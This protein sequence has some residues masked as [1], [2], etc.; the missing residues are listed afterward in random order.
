[1][2]GASSL[3]FE[4]LAKLNSAGNYNSVLVAFSTSRSAGG[5]GTVDVVSCPTRRVETVRQSP[6]ERAAKRLK[7][8][9]KV[10]STQSRQTSCHPS[11][12]SFMMEGG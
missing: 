2:L 11:S 6:E 10:G 9:F 1:M 3:C 5:L 12:R 8:S 4:L 7:I